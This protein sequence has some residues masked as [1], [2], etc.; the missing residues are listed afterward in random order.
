MRDVATELCP[1]I[2]A[3][4]HPA[5]YF[6]F[7]L[8]YPPPLPTFLLPSISSALTGVY[9]TRIEYP[10]ASSLTA[11]RSNPLVLVA[12]HVSHTRIPPLTDSS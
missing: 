9:Q 12:H 11:R 7:I 5:S 6:Q 10:T 8:L 2:W 4:S 3:D 1:Y